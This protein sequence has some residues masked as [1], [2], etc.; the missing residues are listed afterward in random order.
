MNSTVNAIKLKEILGTIQVRLDSVDDKLNSLEEVK[1]E[2]NFIKS[3]FKDA[4]DLLSL[5]NDETD[6]KKI[7]RFPKGGKSF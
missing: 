4:F 3:S 7:T 2:V 6:E 1:N 5:K